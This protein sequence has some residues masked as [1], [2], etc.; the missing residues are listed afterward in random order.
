MGSSRKY[1]WAKPKWF[2]LLLLGCAII[3]QGCK[4]VDM[5]TIDGHSYFSTEQA[6]FVLDAIE[7]DDVALLKSALSQ[8]DINQKGKGGL[9]FLFYSLLL[10]RKQ[11]FSYLL[12]NGADPDIP[13]AIDDPYSTTAINKALS[14]DDDYYFK[15]LL[16]VSD[17]ESKDEKGERPVHNAVLTDRLDRLYQLLAHKA[18]IN[19][20]DDRGETPVYILC[21]VGAYAPAYKLI[22]DGADPL[23]RNNVGGS[24]ALILQDR[25]VPQASQSF[26]IVQKIREELIRR[27]VSFPVQRKQVSL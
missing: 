13:F 4:N 3:D 6:A 19:G 26:V 27:G 11:A 8:V 5:N 15:L 21:S 9:T 23:I 18:D 25:N 12:A 7:K 14:F 1:F 16:P 10:E 24:I 2:L 22:Q 20:R 17:L